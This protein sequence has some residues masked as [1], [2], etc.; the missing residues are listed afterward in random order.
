MLSGVGPARS[1]ERRV[2]EVDGLVTRQGDRGQ[3]RQHAVDL[4][5]IAQGKRRPQSDLK[6]EA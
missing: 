3:A 2:A 5:E 6:P 4:R 1:T